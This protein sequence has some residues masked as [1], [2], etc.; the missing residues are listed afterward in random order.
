[1]PRISCKLR[2]DGRTVA[3]VR[4]PYCPERK[5]KCTDTYGSIPLNADPDDV[6]AYIRLA[7]KY[8]RL[9]IED[10]F[11]VDD[12]VYIR[13]WLIEHGDPK[14]NERRRARDARV[15]RDV[16]ERLRAGAEVE[17]NPLAQVVKLLPAAGE[18]LHKLS[19]ECRARGQDPF[20]HLRKLYMDVLDADKMFL[21]LAEK[22]GV[23]KKM[24]RGKPDEAST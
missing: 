9:H 3:L 23:R 10:V 19:E 18:M 15:E 21:Q 1:M 12:L 11:T 14:G 2:K 17:A 7:K 20:T 16:L 4:Y 8:H 24:K 22:A 6:K 13:D 5:S